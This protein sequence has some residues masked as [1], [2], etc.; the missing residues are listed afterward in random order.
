MKKILILL[1]FVALPL[2]AQ[3]NTKSRWYVDTQDSATGNSVN[4]WANVKDA[5]YAGGAKGNGL[6][7]DQLAIQAAIDFVSGQGGGRVYFPKGTYLTGPITLR[8]H[9]SLEGPGLKDYYPGASPSVLKYS[10]STGNMFTLLDSSTVKFGMKIEGLLFDGNNTTG[11]I[12]VLG[13]MRTII[14]DCQF[15]NASVGVLFVGG[16]PGSNTFENGIEHC[17]FGGCLTGIKSVGS[18]A[19][20]SWVKDCTIYAMPPSQL[21]HFGIQLANCPGWEISGTHIYGPDSAYI[22]VTGYQFNLHHVQFDGVVNIGLRVTLNSTIQAPIVDNC[23]FTLLHPNTIGIDVN[24]L[25]TGRVKITSNTFHCL[26]DTGTIGIRVRGTSTLYGL[27]SENIFGGFWS[28]T[29]SLATPLNTDYFSVQDGTVK[30]NSYAISL[31]NGNVIWQYGTNSPL[32]SVNSDMGSLFATHYSTDS[33]HPSLY[34]R[35]TNAG[36]NQGWERLTS[37]DQQITT[38]TPTVPGY[39]RIIASGVAGWSTGRIQVQGVCA[40]KVSEYEFDYSLSGTVI[41]GDRI[42]FL[43]TRHGVY[44]VDI[45]DSVRLGVTGFDSLFVDLHIADTTAVQK[46]WVYAYGNGVSGLQKWPYI[47]STMGTTESMSFASMP[48]DSMLTLPG[49]GH[50]T[51]GLN[52][53]GNFK[54]P[55]DAQ[56]ATFNGS[57][58]INLTQDTVKFYSTNARVAKYFPGTVAGDLFSVSGISPDG[59]TSPAAGDNSFT[60]A[61]TDS[62]IVIRGASSNTSGLVVLLRKLK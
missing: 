41:G 51:G 54:T 13:S 47:P 4:I 56:A 23:I 27:L 5:L 8:Q 33:T 34:F 6:A 35:A 30:T 14:R 7:N 43:P 31:G 15:I 42:H 9:V 44:N 3:H 26:N 16:L 18:T 32:G 57:P 28:S 24:T 29:T 37:N 25:A 40:G 49:G 17:I 53:G 62:C 36:N 10:G 45:I 46:I 39:Y 52:L 61:K 50:L 59:T 60:F 11:S 22:D 38:F 21:C 20:D 55:G 2:W 58:P 48:N 1:L 19:T 12:L